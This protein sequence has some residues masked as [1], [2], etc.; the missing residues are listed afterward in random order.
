MGGVKGMNES[1]G[2]VC[3]AGWQMEDEK[4]TNELLRLVCGTGRPMDVD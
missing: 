4:A 1:P 2:L 3:G